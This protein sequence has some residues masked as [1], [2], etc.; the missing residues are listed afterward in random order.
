VP[1]RAVTTGACA[2]RRID[3]IRRPDFLLLILNAANPAPD[4]RRLLW[5]GVGKLQDELTGEC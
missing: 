1:P 5:T 3:Q 4:R 2:G